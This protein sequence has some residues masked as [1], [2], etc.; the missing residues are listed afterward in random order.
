MPLWLGRARECEDTDHHENALALAYRSY[1][2]NISTSSC[3]EIKPAA[4]GNFHFLK[5]LLLTISPK[6]DGSS[7]HTTATGSDT[8]ELYSKFPKLTM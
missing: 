8:G 2:P 7:V 6:R 3:P 4:V 5:L 1:F